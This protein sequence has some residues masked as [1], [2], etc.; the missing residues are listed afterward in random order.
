MVTELNLMATTRNAEYRLQISNENSN[1]VQSQS[2]FEYSRSL[3][4]NRKIQSKRKTQSSRELKVE[5]REVLA[6]CC[7]CWCNKEKKGC[8]SAIC[9]VFYRISVYLPD[10]GLFRISWVWELKKL[11][12]LPRGS[13]RLCLL[14][15]CQS[16]VIVS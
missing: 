16:C 5:G 7:C 4:R 10:Q 1:Q 13:F 2:R 12:F 9:D 14:C 3:T 11:A 6:C 15:F 8:I